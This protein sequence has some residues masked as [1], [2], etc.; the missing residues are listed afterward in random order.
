[1]YYVF[2]VYNFSESQ[3]DES[4]SHSLDIHYWTSVFTPLPPIPNLTP[5]ILL[6]F[7][8]VISLIFWLLEIKRKCPLSLF[9]FTIY[10]SLL[11]IAH[12][13][14]L[15]LLSKSPLK[16]KNLVC[17]ISLPYSLC[18]ASCC[19]SILT[20]QSILNRV[21]RRNFPKPFNGFPFYSGQVFKS[22]KWPWSCFPVPI[23]ASSTGVWE[24]SHIGLCCS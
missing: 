9:T 14:S 5:F 17:S 12:Q 2:K 15:A 22:W 18:W 7:S 13:R 19:R 3:I 4:H 21:P 6:A 20:P 24:L 16:K 8:L 23:C 1:M 10:L 11:L